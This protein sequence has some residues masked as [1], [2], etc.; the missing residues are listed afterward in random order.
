MLEHVV[1]HVCPVEAGQSVGKGRDEL[2][3]TRNSQRPVEEI[4][5][6][7]SMDLRLCELLTV[8][9]LCR[10]DVS[11]LR[12]IESEH[13]MSDDLRCQHEEGVVDEQ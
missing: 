1:V 3:T 7:D 11:G 6:D 12:D 2:G 4:G 5:F 10:A 8:C 13:G 9:Q